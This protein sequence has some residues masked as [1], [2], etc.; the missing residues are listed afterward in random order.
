METKKKLSWLHIVNWHNLKKTNE[1]A[2]L[3]LAAEPVS[4][5]DLWLIFTSEGNHVYCV[6]LVNGD[7]IVL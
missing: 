1:E 2:A 6:R 3:R 4:M 5:E 7:K